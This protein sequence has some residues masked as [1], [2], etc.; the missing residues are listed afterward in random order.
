VF[1]GLVC[2][3]LAAV[4]FVTA[5]PPAHATLPT[6]S[7]N[8]ILPDGSLGFNLVATG[9]GAPI[10]PGVL[11]TLNPQPLP[12]VPDPNSL[13]LNLGD[14]TG[15]IALNSNSGG[16]FELQWWM[17]APG[18]LL[19]PTSIPAPD[20]NGLTQFTVDGVS[21]NP[22]FDVSF[23]V[24]PGP[25][26][27]TSWVLLNPQ[28]LPPKIGFDGFGL[29]FGDPTAVEFQVTEIVPNGAPIALSF[30]AVPE[31]SALALLGLGLTGVAAAGRKRRS[32]Q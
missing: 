4:G 8:L 14:P 29:Q 31:P 2:A 1:G 20:A 9:S 12:P 21:G 30:S 27:P 3:L 13:S 23:H 19:F 32:E 11:V 6:L 16:A 17:N 28:P 18:G 25:V 10:N 24:G 22:L 26:D 5:A 7:P 15:P